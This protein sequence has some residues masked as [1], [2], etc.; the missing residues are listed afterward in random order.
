MESKSGSRAEIARLEYCSTKDSQLFHRDIPMRLSIGLALFVVM[1]SWSSSIVA[2]ELTL[3]LR[4]QAN[5]DQ[6]KMVIDD[7]N[8]NGPAAKLRNNQF[9]R[10]RAE[11]GDVIVAIDGNPIASHDDFV[12]AMNNSIDG[13]LKLTIRN[14]KD[15]K[16]SDFWTQAEPKDKEP[17]LVMKGGYF[18]AVKTDSIPTSK[19]V[20]SIGDNNIATTIGSTLSPILSEEPTPEE[21]YRNLIVGYV[22]IQQDKN[23][24]K[25]F[26]DQTYRQCDEVLRSSMQRLFMADSELEKRKI[27]EASVSGVLDILRQKLTKFAEQNG[28]TVIEEA[29][30]PKQVVFRP[31]PEVNSASVQIMHVADK[32]LTLLRLRIPVDQPL[33]AAAINHLNSSI[34]WK[35]LPVDNASAYGRYYYRFVNGDAT[36]PLTDFEDSRQ[37][38]ITP[39]TPVNGVIQFKK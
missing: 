21:Q 31:L 5:F 33:N 10:A 4:V 24:A 17:F 20:L 2:D 9:S 12:E 27:S 14:W 30:T 28:K 19:F 11:P 18:R 23:A 22:Q 8:P 29:T 16:S 36:P 38:T 35:T 34:H 32:V 7:V 39:S 6:G 26:D 15:G 3:V 37:I 25:I 1:T 13:N